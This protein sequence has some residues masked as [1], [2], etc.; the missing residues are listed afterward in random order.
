MRLLQRP[1]VEGSFP[2][3]RTPR[4]AP[5]LS[6]PRNRPLT[7]ARDVSGPLAC[8]RTTERLFNCEQQPFDLDDSTPLAY[9][10]CMTWKRKLIT[11]VETRSYLKRASKLMSKEEQFDAV[12]M[13]ASDPE[14]GAV[15]R[16]TGGIRKVRFRLGGRGKSGGVRLI[17]YFH[18]LT[19]PV[20]LLTVFAKN[21]KANLSA[22]ERATLK[23]LAQRLTKA[24]GVKR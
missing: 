21:E 11:V 18:N 15:M 10:A 9:H 23:V 13:I 3:L 2:S 7:A 14:S 8:K 6:L 22:E 19:M 24:Y 5:K 17:Y 12:T 4:S 20:F 1:A 16:G